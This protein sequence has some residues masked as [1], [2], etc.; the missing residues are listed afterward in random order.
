VVTRDRGDFLL[1]QTPQGFR[2]DILREAYAK[3]S[4]D[5]TTG[6][7]D[8]SLVEAAGLPVA[9]IPG[10]RRTSRSPCPRT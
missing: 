3:A 10:R 9:A 1:A 7:D 4:R 6:T 2:A 5:G 8:A